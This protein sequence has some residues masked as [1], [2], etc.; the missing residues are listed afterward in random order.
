MSRADDIS[1]LFNKLGAN[2]NGYREMYAVHDYLEDD[3]V[4]GPFD[5]RAHPGQTACRRA[6]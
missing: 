1:K 3:V 4:V 5:A 2:P 6:G